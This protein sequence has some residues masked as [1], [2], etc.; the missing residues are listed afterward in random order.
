MNILFFTG[1]DSNSMVFLPLIKELEKRGHNIDIFFG[2]AHNKKR[3][4]RFYKDLNLG[5]TF[6]NDRTNINKKYHV[7]IYAQGFMPESLRS[8]LVGTYFIHCYFYAIV[9]TYNLHTAASN[10]DLV[11]VNGSRHKNIL[12]K[13]GYKNNII[14]TSSPQYN[15]LPETSNHNSEKKVVLFLDPAHSPASIIGKKNLAKVLI[16]TAANNKEYII[17]I[18]P[19][20]LMGDLPVEEK[21]YH[22]YFHILNESNGNLPNNLILLN[23]YGDLDDLTVNSEIVIT[24]MSGAIHPAIIMGKKILLLTGDEKEL[25]NQYVLG[26]KLWYKTYEKY[27]CIIDYKKLPYLLKDAARSFDKD[28]IDELIYKPY[29]NPQI[30]ISNLVEFIYEN[31]LSNNLFLPNLNLT[32]E[33]YQEKINTFINNY[34]KNNEVFNRNIFK[35][36]NLTHKYLAL[37]S[38]YNSSSGYMFIDEF[39]ILKNYLDKVPVNYENNKNSLIFD[40][41]FKNMESSISDYFDTLLNDSILKYKNKLPAFFKVSYLRE[42]FDKK[43]Y[44]RIINVDEAIYILDYYY[45]LGNIFTKNNDLDKAIENYELYIQLKNGLGEVDCND[46]LMGQSQACSDGNIQYAKLQLSILYLRKFNLIKMIEYFP[47]E[48]ITKKIYKKIKMKLKIN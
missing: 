11:L 32:I 40:N 35:L 44:E 16:D 43:D 26:N 10:D 3:F 33:N 45:Y 34:D 21:K 46:Y 29:E 41:Y 23:D 18:K 36:N 14:Y 27:N 4:T 39:M 30:R 31:I 15:T 28:E 42:L 17:K 20:M 7:A 47:V 25:Y 6:Y 38:K 13:N 1:L 9:D 5:Y 48:A 19:R 37:F 2:M 12:I 24:L 22:L 8:K